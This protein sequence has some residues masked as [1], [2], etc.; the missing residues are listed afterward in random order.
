MSIQQMEIRLARL[1]GAYEQI[2]RRLSDLRSELDQRFGGIDQRFASLEVR[3]DAGFARMDHRF[4][5]LT[6][7]FVSM[8]ITTMLALLA[9]LIRR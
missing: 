9:L 6:G 3:M 7:L 2:D 8:W 4:N 1:E 5:W